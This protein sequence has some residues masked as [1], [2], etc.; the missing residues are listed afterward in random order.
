VRFIAMRQC[1]R[2]RATWL[3]NEAAAAQGWLRRA[4]RILDDLDPVHYVH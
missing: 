3:T 2:D 1:V 4:T